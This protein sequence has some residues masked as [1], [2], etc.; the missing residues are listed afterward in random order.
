MTLFPNSRCHFPFFEK[1][2]IIRACHFT[3]NLSKSKHSLTRSLSPTFQSTANSCKSASQCLFCYSSFIYDSGHAFAVPANSFLCIPI[4]SFSKVGVPNM[5]DLSASHLPNVPRTWTSAIPCIRQI[6]VQMHPLCTFFLIPSLTCE[7]FQISITF[8]CFPHHTT[9]E[10][11][12]L[13]LT[14]Y[15]T[16]GR[17]YNQLKPGFLPKMR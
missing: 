1:H 5:S 15:V 13:P 12:S 3:S 11:L 17:L 9:K 6:T 2:F 14:S 16:V 7:L 8:F 10:T 4:H